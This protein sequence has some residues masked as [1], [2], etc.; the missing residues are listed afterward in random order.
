MRMR[1]GVLCNAHL[2]SQLIKRKNYATTSASFRVV[3]EYV[4]LSAIDLQDH[5]IP[6]G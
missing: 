2:A 5:D 4:Y 3:T 6:S 1:H